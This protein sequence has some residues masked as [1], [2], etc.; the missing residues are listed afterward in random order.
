MK[1]KSSLLSWVLNTIDLP[2]RFAYTQLGPIS[3]L[4]HQLLFWRLY[5][6][7]FK[8]LHYRFCQIKKL[9]KKHKINLKNKTVLEIG[10]GNSFIIAYNFLSLGAKKIILLDKFPRWLN[11]KKQKRFFR[12]EL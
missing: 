7:D 9:L 12:Q 5:V 8:K 1:F 4:I 2:I 10:P 3:K 11:S 6:A